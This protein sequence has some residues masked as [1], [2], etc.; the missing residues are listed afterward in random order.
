[1]DLFHELSP[2]LYLAMLV[3]GF[4][5]VRTLRQVDA[6]Q[7]NLFE[8]MKDIEGKFNHLEGEHEAYVKTGVHRKP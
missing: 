5:I 4:F 6:N 2:A 7:K 8:R 3:I 1:M